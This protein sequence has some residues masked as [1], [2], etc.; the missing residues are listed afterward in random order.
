MDAK[1]RP[2]R[3]IKGGLEAD[4]EREY[5]RLHPAVQIRHAYAAPNVEANEV[6]V[7]N[8]LRLVGG[9]EVKG[10]GRKIFDISA[11]DAIN[12]AG[13]SCEMRRQRAV[14][15]I[16][17][18]DVGQGVTV[19]NLV[20]EFRI[21]MTAPATIEQELVYMERN[22]HIYGLF[23]DLGIAII[24]AAEEQGLDVS[25][26]AT[27]FRPARLL[28]YLPQLKEYDDILPGLALA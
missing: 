1:K 4:K 21:N 11:G 25:A 27:V 14:N 26:Y 28:R 24:A 22:G 13:A 12:W 2:L 15:A 6:R 3:F 5:K 7:S 20:E 17:S 9:T 23:L 8:S 19:L 16:F 18:F 10:P